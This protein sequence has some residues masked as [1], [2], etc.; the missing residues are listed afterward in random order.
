MTSGTG[1]S[2]AVL[3]GVHD[4]SE[5]TRLDGVRHNVPALREL[6][7]SADIGGLAEEDCTVVP[8][9][10]T[11]QQLL[12]ALHDAAQEATDLLLVY[13]AGHG[14]FGGRDRSFLLA[15]RDSSGRRPYHSVKYN[16]IRDLV[17]GSA[18]RRKVVVIDCCFSGRALSMADEQTPTQLDMEITGACVL[19]SAA[20][21]ERSLCLPDGSVFT[22][23]LTRLLREGLSGELTGGRR[24]EH[25]PDLTM[26]D[27]FN[28]LHLRLH[29]R[30]VDGLRVPQPRMSTRDLGHQIVLARNRAYTGEPDGTP[31]HGTVEPSEE[32][33]WVAAARDHP[34]WNYVADERGLPLLRD[35]ATAL[36]GRAAA[37]TAPDDGGLAGDPWHS[38]SFTDRLAEWT[39]SLLLDSSLRPEELELSAAEVFL[40]VTHPYLHAAFWQHNASQY[41]GIEPTNLADAQSTSPARR[42]YELFLQNQ[43]RLVRRALRCKDTDA[44]DAIGWW[45]FRRWLVRQARLYEPTAVETLLDRLAVPLG[46]R[47]PREKRLI[48]DVLDPSL[49]ARLL[50]APQFPG[51]P[52][53]IVTRPRSV[54]VAE[55]AQRVRAQQLA[56]LLRFAHLFAI[57][58]IAL[59]DVVADH[60]GIGYAVGLPDLHRTLTGFRWEPNGRTRILSAT[61]HH[62]A[63]DLGLRQ[64]AAALDT[65]LARIDIS[66][67]DE[68]RPTLLRNLPSHVTADQVT[69]ATEEH[70]R[71]AYESTELRFRL[72]DDR[73]QEML[74]GEEL[75]GDPALAIRELYQ[76][77]LDACRYRQARTAYLRATGFRQ[78]PYQGKITFTQGVDEKGPYLECRDNGIGMGEVELRDVFSH[79]GMRFADLPE[80]IEE[81]ARWREHGITMH[82][83]SQF[84][85]G[86]LSYFM[87]ADDI[88]VTTCRLTPDGLPGEHLSV[89]IAGPGSLFRIQRLERCPDAYTSVRLRLRS[90]DVASCVDVLR[91]ILWLSDFDVTASDDRGQKQV[92]EARTLCDAAPLGALDPH[93]PSS[94][95]E[96]GAV[97]VAGSVPVVWW[98]NTGGAVLAD[99]LWAGKHL[100]GAVVNLSGEHTPRLTVDRRR[101]I[102]PDSAET[103]RLLRR[104]IP[105]LLAAKDAVFR[106]D[107]LAR[108]IEENPGL[109]D[110]IFAEAVRVR[111]APW[112]IAGREVDITECGYFAEDAS[113]ETSEDGFPRGFSTSGNLASV[114]RFRGEALT[115][116]GFFPGFVATGSTSSDLPVPSDIHILIPRWHS[117]RAFLDWGGSVFTHQSAVSIGLISQ[118]VD[119]TGRSAEEVATR[120]RELGFS[121]PPAPLPRLSHDDLRI[122]SRDLDG[123]APWIDPARTVSIAHIAQAALTTGCDA[124]EVTARL[125]ELGHRVPATPLPHLDPDD[126]LMI[127]Q[128]LNGDPPWLDPGAVV[129]PAHV[130]RA[131]DRTGSTPAHVTARLTQ[132]G[133]RVSA[134]SLPHLGPDDFLIIS[135]YLNGDPPWLDPGAVVHLAF[136]TQAASATERTTDDITTR[137]AQLGY[138][139]P[140]SHVSP[141]EPDDLLFISRDLD[142]QPP[143]LD[144]DEPVQPAHIQRVS[145]VTRRSPHTI[146][147]R[148]TEL[149]YRL[150]DSVTLGT[151]AHAAEP[152]TASRTKPIPDKNF[153]D[154]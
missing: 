17:S 53:K 8:H 117:S 120:L 145:H 46:K 130:F 7:T 38:P 35:T 80:Y 108:V 134:T 57:D 60:I 25:M 95:R 118:A 9:D 140:D 103:E 152:S 132:L 70:G 48:E 81:K 133:H 138:R 37:A 154:G 24:G 51:Q 75:Y 101:T 105:S 113:T 92:W 87:L 49:I 26:T 27:V 116:A 78:A 6:L 151:E 142:A 56:E 110:D 88:T 39:D 137:L 114:D 85:V 148:L 136:I 129:H 47:S 72:A 86:V 100:F 28:T 41:H 36:V 4:F 141:P 63:V 150:P 29:G 11:Q 122:I 104:E 23:E 13:Y 83:N 58:P 124:E 97:T 59:P 77:A 31:G 67:G 40:L 79:A 45:L 64:H 44:S 127:S 1:R 126:F 107:W 149:G 14:H 68:E 99:G 131:A 102:D 54:G 52:E 2:R 98:C 55:T 12:D 20:E 94:V 109:A 125:R 82:P 42:G 3:F 147:T 50:R 121:T 89:E 123:E 34:L 146:A 153:H 65:L 144:Y 91:R 93:D 115:R 19:T 30:T 22:L 21:T 139:I 119:R 84:G 10:G 69:P 18:A 5:L 74:M 61:C 143:W 112:R 73:I 76:N 135:L 62:L 43:P 16:D 128:H 90:P 106:H 71:A 96:E 32:H 66:T 111:F 15:T 33:E